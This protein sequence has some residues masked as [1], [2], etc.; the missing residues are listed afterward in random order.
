MDSEKNRAN[1]NGLTTTRLETITGRREPPQTQ[2]EGDKQA[3]SDYVS[4]ETRY[5]RR[6][7]TRKPR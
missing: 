7:R 5:L 4:L 2:Q 3:Q 1:Y 6:I